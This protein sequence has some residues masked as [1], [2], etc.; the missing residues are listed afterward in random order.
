MPVDVVMFA[1]D[2]RIDRRILLA[3]RTLMANGLSVRLFAPADGAPF[4]EPDWIKRIGAQVP[5]AHGV[6]LRLYRLVRDRLP[7]LRGVLRWLTW[8]VTRRPERAFI[9]L[10]APALE[11][12]AARVYIAHDLPMLPVAVAARGLHGG[13]I[14]LDSHE[15]YSE[16]EFSIWEKRLWRR[17]ETRHIGGADAVI[18]VNPSIAREISRR[19]G[20]TEPVVVQNAELYQ[21]PQ[22]KSEA[23]RLRQSLSIPDSAKLFLYQGGLTMGR[24]IETLVAAFG[25]VNDQNA[26]LAIL[27][28]G[29]ALPFL[30]RQVRNLGLTNRVRFHPAVPQRELLE[31]TRGADF[32]VI[33][34]QANCLNME[35][36][37]PNKLF[38][39]IMAR[40]PIIATDLREVRR[41]VS[42]YNIGLLGD[43]EDARAFARLIDEA[44]N[45]CK[46]LKQTWQAGLERAALDLCWEREEEKYLCVVRKLAGDEK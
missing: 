23:T 4:D 19:H 22:L 13:K 26:I 20:V 45:N 42:G 31:M 7:I 24:N 43:T 29:P 39:F 8:R 2:R 10:F 34:Y 11:C 1:M 41:I 16:Q 25:H 5:G 40:V 18:T 17:V 30:E 28:D 15:L 33:P 32:G 35:L 38:E 27:G 21:P 36:C 44:L 12:A 9:A 3:A 37:T 14:L 6:G 46:A